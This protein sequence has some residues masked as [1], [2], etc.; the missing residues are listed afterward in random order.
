M[1]SDGDMET[2]PL[3]RCP[4]PVPLSERSCNLKFCQAEWSTGSWAEVRTITVLKGL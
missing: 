2:L 1:T 3:Y 4:D